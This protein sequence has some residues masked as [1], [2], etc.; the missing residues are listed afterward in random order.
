MSS[1]G[2]NID[3]WQ[4]H[5]FNTSREGL[6]NYVQESIKTIEE[7]IKELEDR[8]Y[9]LPDEQKE[10]FDGPGADPRIKLSKKS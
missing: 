2:Q 3:L 10:L 7:K 8:I 5:L 4:E 6:E 9:C 1:N